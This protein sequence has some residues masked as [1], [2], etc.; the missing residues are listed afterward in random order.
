MFSCCGAP[1]RRRRQLAAE[2]SDSDG[3]L[4]ALETGDAA[5]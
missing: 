2:D 1:S 4:I 3:G 5:E